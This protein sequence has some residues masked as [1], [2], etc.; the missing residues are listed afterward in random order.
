MVE[1]QK[2]IAKGTN[3]VMEG[4]DIAEVVLP[5]ANLKIYLDASEEV[6]VDRFYER[7]RGNQRG[8]SKEQVREWIKKR[9]EEDKNRSASPLKLTR[10]MWHLD[11][12]NM[13]LGEVVD[14]IERRVKDL[15][16]LIV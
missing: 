3:V 10:E 1:A 7:R 5:N 6:R 11:S 9:D 15:D 12:S 8:W 14:S 16:G 4:R 13:T 2:R